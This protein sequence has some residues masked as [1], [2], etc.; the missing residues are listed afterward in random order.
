MVERP[1]CNQQR[2]GE[3]GKKV[4]RLDSRHT[5]SSATSAN[6]A[7]QHCLALVQTG[8]KQQ[9]AI[10]PTAAIKYRLGVDGEESYP[11]T[12]CGNYQWQHHTKRP[13]DPVSPASPPAPTTA[14]RAGPDLRGT[15]FCRSASRQQQRCQTASARNLARRD[16]IHRRRRHSPCKMTTSAAGIA[17]ASLHMRRKVR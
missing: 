3:E 7:P 10:A 12:C 13:D 8:E 4:A 16:K 9:D 1:S 14:H 17:I 15:V 6:G 11:V 5:V 2:R